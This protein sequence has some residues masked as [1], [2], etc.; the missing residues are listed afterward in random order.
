[1]AT[2]NQ[3]AT[4]FLEHYGVGTTTDFQ[5]ALSHLQQATSVHDFIL[6]FTKLSSRAYGWT[7]VQ[8]LL[9][10]LGGLKPEIRHD[11]LVMEPSTLATAQRLARLYESKLD[12]I[13]A[14]RSTFSV[15]NSSPAT[16]NQEVLSDTQFRQL[17]SRDHRERRAQGLCRLQFM[18]MKRSL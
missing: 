12:D 14:S 10:F 6:A 17:S 16:G 13:K 7:E 18:V 15:P 3:F 4:A 1:M 5:T 11:V 2:W 8:L 9:I